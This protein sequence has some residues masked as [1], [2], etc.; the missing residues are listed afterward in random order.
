M[1]TLLAEM[2]QAFG[3]DTGL[4]QLPGEPMVDW[5]R[6]M[7][8]GLYALVGAE[9][10]PEAYCSV[11]YLYKWTASWLSGENGGCSH[12]CLT[13][14]LGP[15]GSGEL[16]GKAFYLG[17]ESPTEVPCGRVRSDTVLVAHVTNDGKVLLHMC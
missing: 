10:N 13:G 4:N 12:V 5:V 17:D 8:E 6:R 11:K 14:R 16:H 7:L 1:P 3:V 2:Q 15:D 9:A